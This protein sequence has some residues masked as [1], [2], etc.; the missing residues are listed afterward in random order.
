[1]PFVRRA[2]PP[3]KNEPGTLRK[4]G[5]AGVRVGS[6]IIGSL[7]AAE[8]GL[9]TAIGGGLG[10][11]GES[12]A[13]YL[14][15]AE[16]DP[17]KIAT[18]AAITAVPLGKLFQTGKALKSALYGGALSGGSTVARELAAGEEIDPKAVGINAALGGAL[19]GLLAHIGGPKT[20]TQDVVLEQFGERPRVL[21]SYVRATPT[22]APR[23]AGFQPKSKA[24][25]Y[26][27]EAAGG[28]AGKS[29]TKEAKEIEK[30]TA[31]KV[32]EEARIAAGVEPKPP[33]FGK[34]ITAPTGQPGGRQSMS[35]RYAKPKK[36]GVTPLAKMLGATEEGVPPAGTRVEYTPVVEPPAPPT[37]PVGPTTRPP[38]GSNIRTG[39]QR[40]VESGR[41]TREEAELRLGGPLYEASAVPV[42]KQPEVMPVSTL[43][44]E[45]RAMAVAE[46]ERRAAEQATP[47]ISISQEGAIRPAD[48]IDVSPTKVE[49]VTRGLL[50]AGQEVAQAM[51]GAA[52]QQAEGPL[53]A[54]MNLFKSR[55]DAAGFGNRA[56]K[57]A[58]AAGEAVPEEGRAIAGMNL[59]REAQ[60]AGLPT[61]RAV[62]VQ[63]PVE[64]APLPSEGLP[65]AAVPEA[66]P[67]LGPGQVQPV[68]PTTAA[69][70]SQ[71]SKAR[72]AALAARQAKREA[73]IP[74]EPGATPPAEAKKYEDL[75]NKLKGQ[76]GA[77]APS[78]AMHL[79]GGLGGAAIGAATDPFDNRL[80][81]AGVGAGVGLG[82]AQLPRLLQS[83]G[84]NPNLAS[85]LDTSTTEG[86]RESAKKIGEAL[87]QIQRANYLWD[88]FGLPANMLA[89]PYGS[90]V[91]GALEATLSGD[92]TR[93]L[94]ALRE[95]ANPLKFG[96]LW[97][98]SQKEAI[99]VLKRGEL[100][101]ADA[102]IGIGKL[103]SMSYLHGPGVYMT[104]GDLAARKILMNA[105]FTDDEARLITL[106]SEPATK[107]GKQVVNFARSG[108]PLAQLLL[109]FSRTP[110][111]IAEQGFQRLPIVGAITQL[112]KHETE[113]RTIAAQQGVS[114][115][116][117]AASYALGS[118]L[119][120]ETAKIVRRY[121]T[122][123]AG[124]YSLPAGMAFAAGE[125]SQ[126]GGNQLSAMLG[127][128]IQSGLVLPTADTAE[129]WARFIS[130]G[131]DMSQVPRGVSPK[132][133]MQ[134]ITPEAP[135]SLTP[136][137][138]R[139]RRRQ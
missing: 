90:A 99:E 53:S 86:I 49:P 13:E 88:A 104:A 31:A 20:Q 1:M 92:T 119:D 107:F 48:V 38:I 108:G 116:I 65:S 121:V 123:L 39:L 132:D 46:A 64:G 61:G 60:A 28:P 120:P 30:A 10:A 98:E 85:S 110:A 19:T 111:N 138:S 6:G 44:S 70:L 11:G 42:V 5:A 74:L 106:T 128:G 36:G 45:A 71:T 51:E 4:L 97:Q 84:A 87:P 93:G 17:R 14:E 58:K 24:V 15:G 63:A 102:D 118:N 35:T 54:L 32:I 52:P 67:I 40:L 139:L 117:S 69:G 73:A 135:V 56:I 62:K 18:E 3:P 8:P 82:A 133:F 68:I 47:G 127:R 66:P 126:R 83:I 37:L 33:T 129:S 131:G 16:Q 72:E 50:P 125:A 79:A 29:A 136:L 109:P 57:A 113:L 41:L 91:T 22:I 12:L 2:A 75:F 27:Y 21:R 96:K 115:A 94:A 95:L 105:G 43:E 100:G 134:L 122:N 77:I 114:A 59:R 80:L 78:L 103:Q 101:R 9:G 81:S 26:G 23:P 25:P 34:T 137:A 112:A 7:I 89:G 130:S 124:R 55:V 76:K